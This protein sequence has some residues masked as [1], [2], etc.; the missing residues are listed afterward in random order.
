MQRNDHIQLSLFSTIAAGVAA[1]VYHPD[2][3]EFLAE[4]IKQSFVAHSQHPKS[5]LPTELFF[6]RI[7]TVAAFS[8]LG[9]L[10]PI[11][12]AFANRNKGKGTYF[13]SLCPLT[14][15]A[16]LA[17]LTTTWFMYVNFASMSEFISELEAQ[18]PG[19]PTVAIYSI[20]PVHRIALY[21]AYLMLVI[22]LI[23]YVRSR[24]FS[25]GQTQ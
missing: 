7:K 21:P 17:A 4:P 15:I 20:V 10:V 8:T 22:T 19:I 23:I 13:R 1:W 18:N 12:A 3:F 11:A 5:T 16:I 24:K 6:H 2:L 9:A 25:E 14:A